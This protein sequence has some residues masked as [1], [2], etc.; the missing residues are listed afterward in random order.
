MSIVNRIAKVTA[1]L[2]GSFTLMTL[3]AHAQNYQYQNETRDALKRVYQ[4]L[5]SEFGQTSTLHCGCN[6][7][8]IP[9]A[10]YTHWVPDLSSC[11][12]Q[13]RLNQ[14]RANRIEVEHIMPAWDFGHQRKCWQEGGR[15]NCDND[16]LFKMMEADLHNVYPTVGEIN[17]DRRHFKFTD[18]GVPSPNYGSCEMVVDFK[19]QRAQPPKRA[20]GQIARAYLYMAQK[21]DVKI[22]SEQLATYKDWDKSYDVT[23]FECRRNELIKQVQGND[24]PFITKRC[25]SRHR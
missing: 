8:Y 2:I 13:V 1:F 12:Y 3:S 14:K 22:P 7:K 19:G 10:Q 4:T 6:I 17:A 9:K 5:N 11:G 20:R 21:Y 15:K 16:E 24:N 25:L 23:A 18:W